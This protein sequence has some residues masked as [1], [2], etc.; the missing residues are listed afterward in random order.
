MFRIPRMRA[1]PAALLACGLA[2]MAVPA[3]AT[4]ASAASARVSPAIPGAPIFVGTPG[5]SAPPA[6]LGSTSTMLYSMIP[7]SPDPRPTFTTVTGVTGPT[8]SLS[9]SGS[10]STGSIGFSRSLTHC[11]VGGCWATWSNGFTGDVYTTSAQNVTITLPAGAN[12]FY[13]YAEPDQF[14]NFTLSAVTASGT[15][16]GPITVNGSSGAKYF[17][18]YTTGTSPL[19]TISVTTADPTGFAI[20]EFGI[21]APYQ[22]ILPVNSISGP[23][24]LAG[25]TAALNIPVARYTPYYAITAGTVTRTFGWACPTGIILQGSDGVQYSYCNGS[26]W[27]VNSGTT[28]AAG[29]LLGLTGS[30]NIAGGPHLTFQV[31]YPQYRPRLARCPQSLLQTLYGNAANGVLN[32]V[33]NPQLLPVYP[34]R[35]A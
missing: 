5:T 3:A 10:A 25:R 32:T 6:T 31:T 23:G 21:S 1:V 12:A 7:F 16:S 8:E 13:F 24:A 26:R 17:G 30:G 15:S 35:C 22:F 4:A 11:K 29:T 33:P 20:G 14:S 27:L 9:P 19:R 2:A 18:F 28:V 34:P